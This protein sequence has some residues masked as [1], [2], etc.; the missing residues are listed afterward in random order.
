MEYGLIAG[1]MAVAIIACLGVYGPALL[2]AF[3]RLGGDMTTLPNIM[4]D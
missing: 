1:L 4:S 2:D 3:N